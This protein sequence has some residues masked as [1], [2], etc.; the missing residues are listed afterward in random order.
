[1]RGYEVRNEVSRRYVDEF[2]IPMRGY[3]SADPSQAPLITTVPN[4]HEGL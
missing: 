3:E 4:P 2:R 1:M